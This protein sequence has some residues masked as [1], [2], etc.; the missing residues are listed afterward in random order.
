MQNRIRISGSEEGIGGPLAEGRMDK[1]L[2]IRLEPNQGPA[3]E[4]EEGVPMSE[5]YGPPSG[6]K[7]VIP[8]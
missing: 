1:S 8:V 5:L 2:I 7:R 3:G 4:S 6:C